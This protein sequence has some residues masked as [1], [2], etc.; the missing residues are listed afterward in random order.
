M[1]ELR[2]RDSDFSYVDFAYLGIG[3][4]RIDNAD[5]FAWITGEEFSYTN[6]APG[7]PNNENGHEDYCMIYG[8]NEEKLEPGLWN[9]MSRDSLENYRFAFI[10]EW[11]QY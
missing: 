11:D 9:D 4:E 1:R 5:G 3:A 2:Q 10:C 7:E 6:W 8:K